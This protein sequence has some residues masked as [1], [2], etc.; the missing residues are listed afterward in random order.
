MKWKDPRKNP[1]ET[2]VLGAEG[3]AS[4]VKERLWLQG[5]NWA[6]LTKQ[7]F[8]LE[9]KLDENFANNWRSDFQF[10]VEIATVF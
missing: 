2:E 3:T 9:A 1:R 6:Q 4:Q 8:K 7:E 10:P 5:V